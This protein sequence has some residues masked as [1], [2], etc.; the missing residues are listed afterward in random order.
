LDKWTF[1]PLHMKFIL[2][3]NVI[4]KKSRGNKLLFQ[5]CVKYVV[6]SLWHIKSVFQFVGICVS[7]FFLYDDIGSLWLIWTV[8]Y[9][10]YV[11]FWHHLVSVYLKLFV[12]YIILDFCDLLISTNL[13]HYRGFVFLA[14]LTKYITS[15]QIWKEK[16]LVMSLHYIN[17]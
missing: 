8:F 5:V 13:G 1:F 2:L 12:F 16:C 14:H 15:L 6:I 10:G 7:S 9:F 4:L 17:F 3:N 11:K